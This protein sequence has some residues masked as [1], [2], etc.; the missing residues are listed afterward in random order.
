MPPRPLAFDVTHLVSRLHRRATTG[1]DR[2]DLAY[3]RHFA[4]SGR[5]ACGLH[6]GL[7]AP[8]VFSPARVVALVERFD[9]KLG[10][11]AQDSTRE[12]RWAALRAWLLDQPPPPAAGRLPDEGPRAIFDRIRLHLVDDGGA[13]PP[14]AL[15]LNVAQSLFHFQR[16]F[17]WL[18]RRP[19]VTPVL[20]AHDLL[21]LDHP[22]FF[23]ASSL[24]PSLRRTETLMRRA[25]AILATTEI[26][27]ERLLLEYDR[28]A[29]GAPPIFVGHPPSPIGAGGEA[30]DPDL[31]ATPYFVM[32]G[33]IEPRKNH[34][35]LLNIWRDWGEAAPKLVLVGIDGWNN[36]QTLDMLEHTPIL[37]RKVLRVSGLSRLD[38]RRLIVGARALLLPSFAE[39]YG[40]PLVEGLSLGAPVIASDIPVFREVAGEAAEFLSPF[41]GPGWRRAL[42]DFSAQLSPRRAAALL[43]AG[44]FPAPDETA[45]FAAVEAFLAD[46]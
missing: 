31:A 14:H 32:V 26:V 22:E 40:L 20:M 24:A 9:R 27:R 43:R 10:E 41:D 42:E 13:P 17:T 23:P 8:H 15:Y 3:A 1:I 18:D 46:L 4:R 12:S 39:G 38:L 35:L 6:F 7:R 29:M 11:D 33:T 44:A 37:R 2:L 45:Y 34:Q 19:D 28:R 16:F 5:L 30:P 25:G 21:P 36:R